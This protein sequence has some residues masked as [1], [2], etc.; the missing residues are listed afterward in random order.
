MS[1]DTGISAFPD[2][3]NLFNWVGSIT[4]PTGTVIEYDDNTDT[5]EGI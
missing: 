1:G 3:E 2:G 4:G 5:T